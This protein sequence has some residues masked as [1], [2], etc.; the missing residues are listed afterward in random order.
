MMKAYELQKAGLDGLAQTK[1]ALKAPAA[2]EVQLKV[3]AASLNYRDLKVAQ[4]GYRKFDYPLVPVSDGV[5]EVVAVGEGVTRF[6]IGDRAATHFHP[7]WFS[8]ARPT[9]AE[10]AQTL[11]GALDG[12]LAELVNLPADWLVKVPGYLTD[13]EAATLPIAALTAWTTLVEDGGLRAGETVLVEGSGGVSIFAIQFASLFGARVIAISSS[14]AKLA[15]AGKLGATHT[16]NYKSN[17]DW[18]Q[19]VL[20]LTDGEG[21]DHVVEVAGGATLGK[22]LKALRS[23]GQ[24]GVI[25]FLDSA[26]TEVDLLTVI[27]KRARIRGV[28]VGSRDA[29]ERMN[30]FLA[31]HELRPVID[32]VF[33]FD[34]VREAFDHLASGKHFG[35]IAIR[36]AA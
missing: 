31:Q 11:G 13:E 35:K 36:V 1:R 26:K 27:G 9:A 21:V 33:E 16:I 32:T 15:R 2:G 34:E 10:T 6:E 18:D 24:I 7:H 25:G 4:G 5:G 20:R 3:K 17:P 29:F 23:G 8:N 14:D 12:I 19:E 30:H 28:L 22:A